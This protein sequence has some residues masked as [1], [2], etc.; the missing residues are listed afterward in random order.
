MPDGANI[1]QPEVEFGKGDAHWWRTSQFDSA[2]VISADGSGKNV[3]TRDRSQYRRM[4]IDTFRLHRPL[5]RNW[6][7]LQAQY[8]AALTDLVSDESWREM[9]EEQA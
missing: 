3:Y 7:R 4:L 6:S 8:G 5:R 9:F 2:L 1:A